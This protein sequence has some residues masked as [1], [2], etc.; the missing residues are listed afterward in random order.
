M[1]GSN[2]A[3]IPYEQTAATLAF[4]AA[5]R[6]G[7][8]YETACGYYDIIA[9]CTEDGRAGA[10][11]VACELFGQPLEA[12]QP[13]FDA[14]PDEEDTLLDSAAEEYG[15]YVNS[16]LQLLLS[17]NLPEEEFY[18]T[19]WSRLNDSILF[20]TPDAKYFAFYYTVI[21]VRIPYFYLNKE[22]WYSL[23]NERFHE[24]LKREVRVRQKISF[25]TYAEIGQQS[26]R[27]SAYLAELGIVRPSDNEPIEVI[28]AYER[29][30]IA[31]VEIVRLTV[32]RATLHALSERDEGDER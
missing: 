30:L 9:N 32:H 11:K 8:P 23:S 7:T 3:G 27:A 26:E 29:K 2:Q 4:Y 28:R 12:G 31:M 22:L 24:L 1:T 10:F 20:E 6:H 17:K 19:L 13:T 16:T 18:E 15:P 25:I 14:G 21:D 5:E